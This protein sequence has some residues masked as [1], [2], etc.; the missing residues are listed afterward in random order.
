MNKIVIEHYPVSK[1]PADIQ[2]AVGD[3]H[4]VTLTLEGDQASTISADELVQQLRRE[5][6]DPNFKGTT[7]EEAVARVRALRDEWDDA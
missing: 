6:A 4:S 3:L 1:L 2:Q 5:K 7:M